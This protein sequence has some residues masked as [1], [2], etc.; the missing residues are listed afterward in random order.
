MYG[1]IENDVMNALYQM[2]N[3]CEHRCESHN[4]PADSLTIIVEDTDGNALMHMM[5]LPINA[6]TRASS[7]AAPHVLCTGMLGHTQ[8]L[9]AYDNFHIKKGQPEMVG[10]FFC[11]GAGGRH[12]L[13]R[14]CAAYLL[15]V[16]SLASGLRRRWT[17]FMS[18]R[19]V[20][21]MQPSSFYY[22]I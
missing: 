14:C 15:Y 12:V 7:A 2:Y 8:L 9:I 5:K 1:C 21:A 11:P 3:V 4:A 16:I 13:Y 18:R 17:H 19:R 6:Q 20:A 22:I 10:L